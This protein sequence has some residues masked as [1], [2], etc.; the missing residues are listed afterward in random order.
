MRRSADSVF[1]AGQ[2]QQAIMEDKSVRSI[3]LRENQQKQGHF[4]FRSNRRS[5]RL[6]EYRH[7]QGQQPDGAFRFVI[8]KVRTC[9]LDN[10]PGTGHVGKLLLER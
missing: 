7:A 2:Q 10:L 4:H 9:R 3:I 5:T 8:N 1:R 6:E